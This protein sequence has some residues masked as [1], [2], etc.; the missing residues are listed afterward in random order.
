MK[1]FCSKCNRAFPLDDGDSPTVKCPLCESDIERPQDE[2]A[3]GVVIGD[4]LIEKSLSK[5]GMGEVFQARQLSLDRE[6]ALKVLQK[7]FTG[8]KEYV[9]SLFREARAAAKINHP[10][11]VQAY[12]VGQD[13][14]VFYFA[15]ELVRGDT[16]KNIL[17]KDG[18]LAPQRGAKI[19]LDIAHALEV[20]WREQKLVHQDIKPDNI[21]VDINGFSKLADLGLAK[22]ATMDSGDENSDEVLGTPQ[23]ISPEQ[24]T[25]VPTDVR[26]DIYSLG[27]T[28]Y[29]I[30][31]G[32][33]PYQANDFTELAHMHNDG[34][35]TP[36]K[37]V[38]PDLP[39]EI[40]RIIIKMMAR[41]IEARY[42]TPEELCVDLEK[43]LAGDADPIKLAAS[44]VADAEQN[45]SHVQTPPRPGVPGAAPGIPRPG[46]PGAAPGM[47]RPGVPG[48]VPG[49]PR[50]GVPGAAP[51][52]PRPGV[53]GAVPG[54]PRPGVPGAAP[55]MPRPGV[56]GAAPGMPRPGVPGAA[57]G[58]PR[59]GVPGAAPGMPRPGVPGAVPGMPRPGVPGAVPGMPRPGVPGAVP[60]MPAGNAA[61][62][63]RKGLIVGLVAVL[64]LAIAGGAAYFF[65][66][67]G[68][69]SSKNKSADNEP[70]T[71][72]AVVTPENKVDK[73]ETVEKKTAPYGTEFTGNK[74][75][76]AEYDKVKLNFP[77]KD[78]SSDEAVSRYSTWMEFEIP[79]FSRKEY[80]DLA[81]GIIDWRGE[82][83]TKN[84]ELLTKV[85]NAWQ[86]L[87]YPETVREY[88]LLSRIM[89]MYSA[90]DEMYRCAPAREKAREIHFK[91]IEDIKKR[92]VE[93]ARQKAEAEAKKRAA[94]QDKIN[95]D[96][97][98]A[99]A[100]KEIEQQK[101]G[102]VETF[103][104]ELDK[105]ME[106][107]LAAL[108]ESAIKHD[109]SILDKEIQKT[110]IFINTV[111][112]FSAAEKNMLRML[113]AFIDKMPSERDNLQKTFDR[114]CRIKVKKH[115]VRILLERGSVLLLEIKPGE[116]VYQDRDG[117]AVT[118]RIKDMLPRT[119]MSLLTQLKPAKI[120]NLE[121]YLDMMSRMKPDQKTVPAGFWKNV[122]KHAEKVF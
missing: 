70:E 89:F 38:K 92:N 56:P 100:L 33:L 102:R 3:P 117:K 75:L 76:L 65:I 41:N 20:A 66:F 8:D 77:E 5:G 16:L 112:T 31:T 96:R 80:I 35:L 84:I 32:K 109:K 2:L 22:N 36:P 108:R 72:V 99:S 11:I 4:F 34:N 39:D 116:L 55:G 110:T 1:L 122:W 6:V 78:K 69:K 28:F 49:M 47:P 25:G 19:I 45:I 62:K 68:K 63:N 46:V 42:Q 113:K 121:F 40:N 81:Q 82:N 105:H 67:E 83:Q 111:Q 7:E 17:R 26:S 115:N 97:E 87:R 74:A 27:A 95:R 106:I 15:M 94:V 37:N 29:H 71:P 52:M 93:I 114:I 107:C 98:N 23:Y 30:V 101:K 18:V 51:G 58:M 73:K 50:P 57:P 21:M 104:A 90:F 88:Q 10:N 103:K 12:A 64:L 79:D 9:E 13:G 54:M 59:P 120:K 118:L 14:D 119:R 53:P 60:G 61:K 48:A 44:P 86:I 91:L 43:Y 24:L 85:D